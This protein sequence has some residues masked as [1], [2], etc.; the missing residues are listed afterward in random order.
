MLHLYYQVK[1]RRSIPNPFKLSLK[2]LILMFLEILL[3]LWERLLLEEM[4]LISLD[5]LVQHPQ[6][7]LQ[8]KNQLKKLNHRKRNLKKQ[9]K[10]NLKKKKWI[11]ED[12]LIDLEKLFKHSI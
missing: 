4:S 10:Q 3:E 8:L 6:P 11:W 7:P 2:L 9:K 12:S 5:Q 1:V